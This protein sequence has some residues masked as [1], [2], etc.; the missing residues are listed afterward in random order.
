MYEFIIEG[1]HISQEV[2]TLNNLQPER[3]TLSKV[4][5]VI[6]TIICVM[7]FAACVCFMGWIGFEIYKTFSDYKP[8]PKERYYAP[9]DFKEWKPVEPPPSTG[10]Y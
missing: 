4:G 7:F 9:P 10:R 2:R 5:E 1:L 3:K 6:A 8:P